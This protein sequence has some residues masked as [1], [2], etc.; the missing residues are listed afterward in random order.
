MG[1]SLF[2]TGTGTGVGKTVVSS[3]LWGFCRQQGMRAVYQKW[4]SSG[5]EQSEDLRFCL[6][7]NS[8]PLNSGQGEVIFHFQ[9]AASPHLAAEREGKMVDPDRIRTVFRQ[10]LTANELVLVE[11]AGG[12]LVPLRR[13]LLFADFVAELSLP[14]LIVARSGLG[15]INHTLLTIEALRGRGI[16]LLGVVLC[17]EE[18]EMAADDVL[19]VDN[20]R[21]IE[22]TGRVAVV[23]RLPRQADYGRL[24]QIFAPIGAAIAARLGGP[25]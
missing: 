4:V 11:G 10:A 25:G 5:G 18:K 9:L 12:V 15:T 14:A 21:V 2:I 7:H 23:G 20:Q 6:E 19:V 24:Q 3:L 13:D 22:E 8:L 17:D 1:K 16:P